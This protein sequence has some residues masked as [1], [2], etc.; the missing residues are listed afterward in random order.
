MTLWNK[1]TKFVWECDN[2]LDKDNPAT[3]IVYQ[4]PQWKIQKRQ[5]I[6]IRTGHHPF[7]ELKSLPSIEMVQGPGWEHFKSDISDG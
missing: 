4:Y 2:N 6:L 3:C 7:A 5:K 1:K